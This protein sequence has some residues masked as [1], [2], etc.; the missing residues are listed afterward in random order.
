MP[1]SPPV[2]AT[3]VEIYRHYRTPIDM[4]F[5]I[6]VTAIAKFLYFGGELRRVLADVIVGF[7]LYNV[8]ASHLVDVTIA[9]SGIGQFTISHADIATIIGILGP[10]GIKIIL[11]RF[12]KSK[13]GI[14]IPDYEFKDKKNDS[15]KT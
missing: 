7:T 5:I 8:V 4:F 9:V 11:S 14:E 13:Y 10:S 15:T 6:L 3:F 12:F 2:L 1:N